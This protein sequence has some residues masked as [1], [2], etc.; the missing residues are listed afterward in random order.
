MSDPERKH[1][2]RA[3]NAIKERRIDNITIWDLHT[4]V[5]YPNSAPAAHWGFLFG[6]T[7]FYPS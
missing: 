1:L 5:H 2:Q 3:L 7:P 4:L 6:N